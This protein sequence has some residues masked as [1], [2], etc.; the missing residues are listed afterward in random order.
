MKRR[1]NISTLIAKQARLQNTRV[2]YIGLAVLFAGRFVASGYSFLFLILLGDFELWAVLIDVAVLA[3]CGVVVY[4]FLR[5]AS[6][7]KAV[8]ED[9]QALER[10][11]DD[12]SSSILKVLFPVRPF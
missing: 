12:N 10:Y 1:H 2:I 8:L 4:S 9:P 6:K 11:R 7:I 5:M 3:L